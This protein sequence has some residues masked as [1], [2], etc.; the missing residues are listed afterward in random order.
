MKK[1]Q[2]TM[3]ENRKKRLNFFSTQTAAVISN[4]YSSFFVAKRV[5]LFTLHTRF[6]I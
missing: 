2:K 6:A 3:V 5:R 4:S 1:Q